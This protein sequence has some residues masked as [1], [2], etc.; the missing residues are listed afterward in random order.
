MG[1]QYSPK[2]ITSGLVLY[3]DAAN[4]KS[5]PGTGTSWFDLSGRNAH[6]TV[7]NGPVFTNNGPSSYILFD[8]INDYGLT[9]VAV[10]DS[11]YGDACCF[12]CMCYGP[13]TN[14]LLT[15]IM[16]QSRGLVYEFT[17]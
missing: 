1:L 7:Y 5:Y 12:E 10:P 3:L 14:E 11:S 8:G 17:S 4:P 13:M 9:T 15:I 16:L 2:I 6:M